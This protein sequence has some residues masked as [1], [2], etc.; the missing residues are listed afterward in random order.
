MVVGDDALVLVESCI[1][2]GQR[3]RALPERLFDVFI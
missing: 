1:W 2:S 3:K